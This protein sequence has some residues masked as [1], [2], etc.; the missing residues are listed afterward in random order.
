VRSDDGP[1]RAI[2]IAG[3]HNGVAVAL[4]GHRPT[5]RVWLMQM[6]HQPVAR[7]WRR[8]CART[9]HHGPNR[10]L[11]I[12]MHFGRSFRRGAPVSIEQLVTRPAVH[13]TRRR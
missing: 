13:V 12:P 4:T 8:S 10:L 1:A 9:W 5:G 3:L 2:T 11:C 6:T 7:G